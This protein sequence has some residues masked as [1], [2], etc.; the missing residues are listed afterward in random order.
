MT[1]QIIKYFLFGLTL[2]FCN[3]ALFGQPNKMD[4]LNQVLQN[5]RQDTT[6]LSMLIRL[7]EECEPTEILK[8]AKPAVE[9]SDKLLVRSSNASVK[10]RER[11]LRQK[12][13][14][15]NN[16]GF[17]YKQNGDML[18][19]LDNYIN[20]LKIR[21]EIGDNNGIASSLYNIGAIFNNQGN[22]P[23]CIRLLWQKPENSGRAW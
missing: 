8:Y 20:S 10:V 7:S 4:S 22:I 11:I 16:I 5:E 21:E 14:A 15:L 13:E 12:A 2:C 19:A 18:L 23:P 1:L 9:L 17:S 3:I 6:K